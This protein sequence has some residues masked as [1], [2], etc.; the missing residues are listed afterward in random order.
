MGVGPKFFSIEW[1]EMN[2]IRWS[3]VQSF[4]KTEEDL[5][6]VMK[7]A[8]RPIAMKAPAPTVSQPEFF[9]NS[10]AAIKHLYELCPK[11][12]ALEEKQKETEM[13]VYASEQRIAS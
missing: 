6:K 9:D 11:K 13:A 7:V 3:G 4:E 2:P 1:A 10:Q 5:R 12:K 8:S